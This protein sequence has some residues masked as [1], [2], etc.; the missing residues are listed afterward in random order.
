MGMEA[1]YINRAGVHKKSKCDHLN[2]VNGGFVCQDAGGFPRDRFPVDKLD[3]VELDRGRR[4]LLPQGVG[5]PHPCEEIVGTESGMFCV[6]DHEV[7]GEIDTE[8]LRG[9]EDGRR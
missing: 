1:E 4:T 8:D 9:I 5:Q 2:K 6:R 7:V 3:S